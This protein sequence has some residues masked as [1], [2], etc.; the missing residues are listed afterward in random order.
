MSVQENRLRI[1]GAPFLGGQLERIHL[2][3]DDESK[4]A[5]CLG[6]IWRFK[7]GVNWN[8][9]FWALF[10]DG[11]HM[12]RICEISKRWI[13]GIWN[14]QCSIDKRINRRDPFLFQNDCLSLYAPGT[15]LELVTWR[16]TVRSSSMPLSWRLIPKSRMPG[17]NV[18][19]IC[20]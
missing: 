13:K 19:R 6:D 9:H 3:K 1:F 7:D 16:P 11:W 12:T 20:S 8:V 18:R 5:W 4:K 10:G 15:F 2:R 14:C 17:K